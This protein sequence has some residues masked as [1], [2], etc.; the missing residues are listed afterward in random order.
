MSFI[1]SIGTANPEHKTEQRKIADFMVKAMELDANAE[2]KLRVLFKTSGINFRY[3]VISDFGKEK[4]Y[5]F[6]SNTGNL[7][8]FPT[9]KCRMSAFRD[10][11]LNL[12]L[13]AINNTISN[14]EL[15]TITHLITVCC[16]GMYA[17]GLDIDIVKALPLNP[18]VHRVCINFMGC[19]AAINALQTA[20]AFCRADSTSRVLVVCTELCSLHFQKNVNEDNLL[21]NAL[22]GDGSAAV[23]VEGKTKKT[24]ALLPLKFHSELLFEG[25]QD[26]GWTIADFGFEMKLT[27]YVP[28]LI[29]KGIT[30]LMDPVLSDLQYNIAD[31]EYF[32]IHPGGKKI[33]KNIERELGIDEEKNQFAYHVLKNYGNMS[34][35]TVLFV[36]QEIFQKVSAADNDKL[37][38]SLAFGPGL[39]LGSIVF[40]IQ[41]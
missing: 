27:S 8:P 23:L 12:S 10:H 41:A 30:K 17:P 16:T 9:T 36:L 26:M 2:R 33:L 24:K 15:N 39:T 34:S 5:D 4:E 13:C 22:F 19:Y 20:D 14:D 40:K 18:H 1:T 31:I 6:F 38:L 21:S 35:P 32:A 29:E 37:V 11:A 25:E 7:E 28:D 3:S